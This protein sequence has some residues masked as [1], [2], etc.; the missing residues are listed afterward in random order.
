VENQGASCAE[1]LIS[2]PASAFV[3][4]Q[5]SFA[6]PVSVRNVCSSIPGTR[7]LSASREVVMPFTRPE[8]AAGRRFAVAFPPEDDGLVQIEP[9]DVLL[10]ALG[11]W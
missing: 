2:T 10:A 9:L 1:R 3:T 5:P 8:R 7:P 11:R 4:G 6:R